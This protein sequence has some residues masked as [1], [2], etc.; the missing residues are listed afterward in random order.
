MNVVVVKET[1]DGEKRVAAVPATVEKMV[2]PGME[3]FVQAG[4]GLTSGLLDADYRAA[5]A[6]VG[7]DPSGGDV[8][9]KVQ[10]P[11]AQEVEQIPEGAALVAYSLQRDA[12]L[13]EGL[14][15]RRISGLSLK[16]GSR[17][18]TTPWAYRRS[19]SAPSPSRSCTC[20]HHPRRSAASAHDIAVTRAS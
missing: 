14:K 12:R 13:A 10:W 1:A 6:K 5:G 20:V 2:A 7:P 8:L 4:A 15:C 3:V 18:G 16:E 11:S 19:G 17:W 9:L